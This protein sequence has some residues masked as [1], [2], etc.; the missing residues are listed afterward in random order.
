MTKAIHLNWPPCW[1]ASASRIAADPRAV[2]LERAATAARDSAHDW[3]SVATDPIAVLAQQPEGGATLE[4]AGQVVDSDPSFWGLWK[5]T[6]SRLTAAGARSACARWIGCLGFDLGRQLERLPAPRPDD[7]GMP[8]AWLALYDAHIAIDSAAQSATAH[9][10]PAVAE[11]LQVDARRRLAAFESLVARW[12][13]V[14]EPPLADIGGDAEHAL[15]RAEFESAV[16]R[17][18]AYIAAGDI[19]QVN[20]ARRLRLFPVGDPL[21]VYLAARATN[22]AAFRA[23]LRFDAAAVAS[24]SPELMLRVRGRD[25]LTSPIKGTRPRGVDAAT[26][27]DQTS[28]L[29]ASPKDAAELAMIVDLHRNDLGRVCTPHSV[30]VVNARR[31]ELHPSVIHTVGDI[32]GRLRADCDAIDALMASFPAGSI[33]GVPKLRALEIIR[34]LEAAPRG[35]YTGAIGWLN[36]A[37][38]ACWSV[39]IRIVQ[40]GARATV[41][42]V[43][44]GIVADSD[45]VSEYEETEHKARGI[46][47][48]MGVSAD[49]AAARVPD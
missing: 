5:R 36:L 1:H 13:N 7:V 4:V 32:A 12:A 3:E 27:Q 34:E 48:A 24:F 18:M 23:L 40:F 31:V 37:G 28:E 6:Q 43:G 39:A 20:L 29:L 11:A 14:P 30:R 25:V 33:S 8:L 41:L 46:L 44:G 15:P 47:R 22:P 2:W 49:G 17:A 45:P 9:H 38:D 42:H 16:R 35:L 21:R 26:D 10:D 19:Y